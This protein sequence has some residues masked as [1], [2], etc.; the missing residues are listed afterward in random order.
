LPCELAFVLKLPGLLNAATLVQIAITLKV[1]SLLMK[2]STKACHVVGVVLGKT[3]SGMDSFISS[4]AELVS[5]PP[6]MAIVPLGHVAVPDV[7][8]GLVHGVVLQAGAVMSSDLTYVTDPIAP[9]VPAVPAV[10]AL[11]A[12]SALVAWL[13]LVAKVAAGTVPSW[14]R[15]SLLAEMAP[16]EIFAPVTAPFLIFLEVTAFFFSCLLPTL[17]LGTLKAA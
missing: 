3:L 4:P 17:F 9:E 1:E 13:A 12:L 2:L 16:L 11:V 6:D 5:T 14:V 8:L 10:P 15:L 7:S